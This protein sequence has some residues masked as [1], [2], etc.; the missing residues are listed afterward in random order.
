[1][2]L[3]LIR[4]AD[5]GD[6]D[7]AK[8]PDDTKRPLTGKGRRQQE[9]MDRRLRRRGYQ[10]DRILVSPWTRAWQ[11]AEIV[12]R[13]FGNAAPKLTACEPLAMMPRVERI[14]QAIGPAAP[15]EIIALVGHEPWLGELASRLL[16]S[17]PSRL[18]IDFPKSGIIGI[19]LTEVKVGAG[20]L[21]F[22][23]R[24]KGS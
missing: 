15:N 6:R 24:P 23:W 2:L 18:D 17:S 14:A 21:Q 22:M 3:L 19:R 11:T 9:R 13:E 10:P 4:H 20:E 12:A 16:T 8:W 7:P 5:A 1:M